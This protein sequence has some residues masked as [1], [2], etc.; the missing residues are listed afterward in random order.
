MR[1]CLIQFPALLF[2]MPVVAEG[3]LL[4]A[5]LG[6]AGLGE[7]AMVGIN[8]PL[9][10]MEQ[11]TLEVAVAQEA[12]APTKQVPLAAPAAQVSS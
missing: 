10:A 5:L 7:G 6:L 2:T 3:L 12:M 9:E 11:Q 1:D 4:L 8:P